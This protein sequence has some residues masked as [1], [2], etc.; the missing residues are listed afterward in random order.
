MV[1]SGPMS[2]RALAS[3]LA[4]VKLLKEKGCSKDEI[5]DF[6]KKSMITN[7]LKRKNFDS[8]AFT[9]K[10]FHKVKQGLIDLMDKYDREEQNLDDPAVKKEFLDAAF[11]RRP[12]RPSSSLSTP[13]YV[14]NLKK[15]KKIINN[16]Y[17]SLFSF[18]RFYD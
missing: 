8:G 2:S 11:P 17:S 6:V 15:Q 7:S 12:P 16:T 18:D 10:L 3:K 9:N 4:V 14:V 5:N 13:T 1:P